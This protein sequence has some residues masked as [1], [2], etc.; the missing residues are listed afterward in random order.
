[1]EHIN[2]N[3]YTL[4]NTHGIW[5]WDMYYILYYEITDQWFIIK[6][7][8]T[9]ITMNMYVIYNHP[10]QCINWINVTDINIVHHGNEC[11]VIVIRT[12][13]SIEGGN[14]ENCR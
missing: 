6:E 3:I 14:W 11:D 5:Q 2:W 12:T 4:Y 7:I 10:T 13:D 8:H 1:M 9:N